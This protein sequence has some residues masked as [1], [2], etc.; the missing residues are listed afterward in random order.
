ME[1]LSLHNNIFPATYINIF[2]TK[3]TVD[4]KYARTMR[5]YF[6]L[7][8]WLE[9]FFWSSEATFRNRKKKKYSSES[10]SINSINQYE[11]DQNETQSSQC[12]DLQSRLVAFSTLKQCLF[13]L[14]GNALLWKNISHFLLDFFFVIYA[15]FRR[16]EISKKFQY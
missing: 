1:F 3:R 6:S 9:F 16:A 7:L 2:E 8:S 15:P 5:N 13:N 14:I 11:N 10:G 12:L 4:E